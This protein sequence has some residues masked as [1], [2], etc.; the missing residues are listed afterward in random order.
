MTKMAPTAVILNAQTQIYNAKDNLNCALD[1]LKDAELALT[2]CEVDV[3]FRRGELREWADF[4]T[5]Q[6]PEACDDWYAEA[7]LDTP[8]GLD[9]SEE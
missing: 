8:V 1:D 3:E 7:G 6:C 2:E 9:T 4:L 5:D